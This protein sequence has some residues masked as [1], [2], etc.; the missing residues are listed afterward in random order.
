[1]TAAFINILRIIRDNYYPKIITS[2]ENTIETPD[3]VIE[4]IENGNENYKKIVEIV[5][6]Y[7]DILTTTEKIKVIEDTKVKLEKETL[8][9]KISE[10]KTGK[11]GINVLIK[12]ED[13]YSNIM[14]KKQAEGEQWICTDKNRRGWIYEAEKGQWIKKG[15]LGGEK[16]EKGKRNNQIVL[17]GE[18]QPI[19]ENANPWMEDYE[20]RKV[21]VESTDAGYLEPIIPGW[22]G[23][24]DRMESNDSS[25]REGV[26]K[27]FRIYERAKQ[28]VGGAIIV[29]ASTFFM[30]NKGYQSRGGNVTSVKSIKVRFWMKITKDR[31]LAQHSSVVYSI[32]ARTGNLDGS[33]AVSEVDFSSKIDQ[34]NENW[35]LI[36]IDKVQ[37]DNTTVFTVSGKG[38]H[39]KG[40]SIYL[41]EF[42]AVD[43]IHKDIDWE[44]V[45]RKKEEEEKRITES[46]YSE[47]NINIK[48][49]G[50]GQIFYPF[51]FKKKAEIKNTR[52]KDNLVKENV[53]ETKIKGNNDKLISFFF[54]KK[55]KT[56]E[57]TLIGKLIMMEKIKEA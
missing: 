40:V 50:G 29:S 7:K 25:R 57:A 8:K 19:L 21:G 32:K 34:Q 15:K 24:Y 5:K 1:M 38:I 2:A 31:G 3:K 41:S 43:N 23:K 4:A 33:G 45:V 10:G 27:E 53:K 37:N 56:K 44:Y 47:I 9:W 14:N 42:K 54:V 28:G 48:K 39:S 51:W 35:Q 49:E 36:E 22:V 20:K 52:I 18:E 12:G 55:D 46:L 6:K 16:G 13:T 17:R 30:G 26:G 11:K